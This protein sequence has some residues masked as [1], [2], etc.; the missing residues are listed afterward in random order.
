MDARHEHYPSKRSPASG[1]PAHPGLARTLT[2]ALVIGFGCCDAVAEPEEEGVAWAALGTTG[3]NSITTAEDPAATSLLLFDVA[4][5]AP[6]RGGYFSLVV[7]AE[8]GPPV[9][10]GPAG[11]PSGHGAEN[12]LTLRDRDARLTEALYRFRGGGGEWAV[13]IIESKGYLDAS[14]VTNDEKTQFSNPVFVNNPTINLPDSNL[15]LSWWGPS[16]TQDHGYS[17]V[18]AT[19]QE[20]GVFLA[21]ETWQAWRTVVARLGAWS[22][23]GRSRLE[24]GG[25]QPGRGWGLYAS[26]DG[27]F[28]AWRWNVRMG[29]ARPGAPTAPKF[30]SVAAELPRGRHTL[31]IAAGHATQGDRLSLDESGQGSHVELYYRAILSSGLAITPSLQFS[32]RSFRGARATALTAGVRFRLSI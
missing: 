18:L 13:G 5:A 2:L 27:H 16:K 3:F 26:L 1:S 23:S 6:A 9:S 7:E 31:G 14:A 25:T 17:A 21:L 22:N 24:T 12:P 11:L 28:D 10:M 32:D 15:G 29:V 4:I 30:I 8:A 20:S 19:R